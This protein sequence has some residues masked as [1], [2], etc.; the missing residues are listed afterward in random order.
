MAETQDRIRKAETR[1]AGAMEDAAE[2]LRAELPSSIVDV[3]DKSFARAKDA[4]EQMTQ[5]VMSSAD[6]FHEAV[7]CANRG[8]LELRTAMMELARQ[9]SDM[10]FD[11]ARE[12]I[13]AKSPTE[14][15]SLMVEHQR[16]VAELASTQAKK[17]TEL[18]Q[19]VVSETAE[20]M[21][22]GITTPF[23]LAS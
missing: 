16:K 20:P 19:K 17:L 15:L 18:G 11:L 14:F 22:Q 9:N 8:S 21:R 6:A 2:T 7:T 3:F 5:M 23:K 12:A 4:H 10:A 13:N 1:A